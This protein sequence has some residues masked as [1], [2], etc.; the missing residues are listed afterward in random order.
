MYFMQSFIGLGVVFLVTDSNPLLIY[1]CY[2]LWFLA[3]TIDTFIFW[4]K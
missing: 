3:L 4:R 1:H 2:S